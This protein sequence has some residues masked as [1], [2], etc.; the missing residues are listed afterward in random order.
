VC[1][2]G[3]QC[4]EGSLDFGECE[5]KDLAVLKIEDETKLSKDAKPKYT[6]RKFIYSIEV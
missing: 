3:P 2:E 5:E 6:R 1:K 4:C